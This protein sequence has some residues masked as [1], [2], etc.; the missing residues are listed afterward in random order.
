[1][2]NVSELGRMDGKVYLMFDSSKEC[3][4]FYQMAANEGMTWTDGKSPMEKNLTNLVTINH[5]NQI[6][7]V[8]I[9]GRTAIQ[10]KAKTVDGEKL[11]K[12]KFSE[13]FL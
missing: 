7:F 9:I 10:G 6:S 5:D 2:K 11:I 12:I 4:L 13:Y 3:A 8:G 1:M